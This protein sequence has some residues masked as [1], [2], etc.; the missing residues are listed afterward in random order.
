MDEQTSWRGHG[1]TLFVFVGIAFLCATFFVLGMLVGRSQGQKYAAA[2]AEAVKPPAKAPDKVDF[3]YE[4]LKKDPAPS[5]T[6]E[7]AT[8]EPLP[9]P[10]ARVPE[11]EAP[12]VVNIQVEALRQQRSADRLVGE[13]KKLGF[14]AFVVPPEAGE[15]GG[16]YRVQVGPFA[17]AEAAEGPRERLQAHGYHPNIKK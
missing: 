5:A 7:A 11:T 6:A 13:L 4:A 1:F 16:L 2:V 17:D 9:E 8:A 3:S 15:S 10:E 14:S 12:A